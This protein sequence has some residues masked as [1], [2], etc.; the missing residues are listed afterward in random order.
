MDSTIDPRELA[1]IFAGGFVGAIARVQLAE[2]LPADPG[3]WPWATF[4]VNIAGALVLGYFGARLARAPAAS[5]RLRF[6][7]TGF[8]GALTTF[9]TLQLELLQMLDGAH[10]ALAATYALVSIA[11]GVTAVT[12]AT[13]AGRR[14]P[15]TA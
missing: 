3:Q 12:L 13:R 11:A 4:A 14:R 1:A 15:A 7:G 8:C 9:A 5:C 10:Y 2:S 6:V